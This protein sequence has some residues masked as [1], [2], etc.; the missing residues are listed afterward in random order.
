MT[1]HRQ[2]TFALTLM[3]V[4]ALVVAAWTSS[5]IADKPAKTIQEL[6]E[7]RYMYDVFR[8]Q[9]NRPE[10]QAALIAVVQTLE[11]SQVMHGLIFLQTKEEG[12]HGKGIVCG[13]SDPRP[14][15]ANSEGQSMESTD[16]AL[17]CHQHI[18]G[19]KETL[20]IGAIDSEFCDDLRQ[21]V[22]LDD[23][24]R[25]PDGKNPIATPEECSEMDPP[26]NCVCYE[27]KHEPPRDGVGPDSPPNSGSGT[28][29]H[30]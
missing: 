17:E 7:K 3:S 21:R 18:G 20:T 12:H 14:S 30:N 6:S 23:D 29:G 5:A 4:T 16:A 13:H 28:G 15:R 19:L 8:R 1:K 26:R 22:T 25:T 11:G 27:I 10:H 24:H 9:A 2:S